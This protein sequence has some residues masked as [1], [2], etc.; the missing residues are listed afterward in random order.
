MAVG[1]KDI[2]QKAGVSLM[3][4]SRALNGA[5]GVGEKTRQKVL[6][7][8]D[9]MGY[10]HNKL[11][12][13]L[14]KGK[15][16]T[17]GVVVPEIE[18]TIFPSMLKG[19]DQVLTAEGYAMILACSEGNAG[20]EYQAVSS[21]L[22]HRVDGLII[23]P[24]SSTKSMTSIKKITN[25]KTPYVFMDRLIPNVDADAVVTD[26]FTGAYDATSHLI[27][28]GFKNIA[29]IS[30]TPESWTSKER[31]CG[32][33]EALADNGIEVNEEYIIQNSTNSIEEGEFAMNCLLDLPI[34]PDAVF[35]INDPV[36]IGAF[37]ALQKQGLNIP[38]DVALVG[39][40]AT[41]HSELLSVP[42]TTVYQDGIALG[43]QSASALFSQIH[44]YKKK[45][46]S[47]IQMLKTHLIIRESSKVK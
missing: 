25:T 44:G 42:L 46:T 39:F 43:Q 31:Q 38:K 26:D 45:E 4:V 30:G 10:V 13:N 35:C 14:N 5:A 40:S 17:I 8:A 33:R 20:K 7:I 47:E 27:K 32:Y 16:Q 34:A 1:L 11:A 18:H 9:E 36:A 24:C 15:T 3:S 37:K 22:E 2:A 21:L 23:A 28:Q 6:K 12:S 29:H 19:I 41:L